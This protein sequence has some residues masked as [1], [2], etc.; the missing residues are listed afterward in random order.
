M[1]GHDPEKDFIAQALSNTY[2]LK[3][4]IDSLIDVQAW[5]VPILVFTNA[6]VKRTALIT[7]KYARR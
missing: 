4:K 2:W 1:N 3:E 7:R 5:I 6:F